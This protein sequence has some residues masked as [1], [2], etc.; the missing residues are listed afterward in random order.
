MTVTLV[1]L[2]ILL[3]QLK[4]T[5][6][7]SHEMVYATV[8]IL[9]KIPL[10]HRSCSIYVLYYLVH[11]VCTYMH[12]FNTCKKKNAHT[13]AYTHTLSL[14]HAQ[15]CV[16]MYWAVSKH[17]LTVLWMSGTCETAIHTNAM[18][19]NSTLWHSISISLHCDLA[20]YLCFA[21]V[22]LLGRRGL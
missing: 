14:C 8:C 21:W 22:L 17:L 20:L 5:I 3:H 1:L 13:H 6:S 12:A 7:M 15:T 4:H 18:Y 16:S 19:I 9:M 10:Y 2:S 11:T